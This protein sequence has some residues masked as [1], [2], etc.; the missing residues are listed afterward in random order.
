MLYKEKL[1]MRQVLGLKTVQE[2]EQ[3][4]QVPRAFSEPHSSVQRQP[5]YHTV[6][7]DIRQLYTA[8]LRVG[9]LI[10]IVAICFVCVT[11]TE[12]DKKPMNIAGHS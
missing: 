10:Y 1:P 3:M 4:M 5:G 8:A 9:S 7:T 12:D 2:P 6:D 11:T